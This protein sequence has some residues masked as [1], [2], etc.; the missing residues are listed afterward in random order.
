M[1]SMGET[2]EGA[3]VIV[4]GYGVVGSHVARILRSRHPD[5]RLVLTGRNPQAGRR[6][7]QT[8]NAST[9]YMDVEEERPLERLMGRPAAVLAA[10]S[11]PRDRLLVH[12]MRLGVPIADIN[13]AGHAHILDAALRVARER[14][15]TPVLL[16]GGWMSGFAALVC[17]AS[18][19]ALGRVERIDIT[20][21]VSSEDR[22]GP[23]ASGFAR[24]LAWP[25][26][27][28]RA[29]HRRTVHPLT[30]VRRAPCPDGR[31][32]AAALVAT[33]EQ[34]TIPLTLGVETVE[35]RIALWSPTSLWGLVALKRSGALRAMDRPALHWLRDALLHRSGAGDIAGFTT[36]VRSGQRAARI[37]VLDVQGQAHLSA[38][39][40]V[41]AA[42]RILGLTDVAL[43]PGLSF[44]EQS[45]QGARDLSMLRA[46]GVLV[47]EHRPACGRAANVP[48]CAPRQSHTLAAWTVRNGH[49][50][51]APR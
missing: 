45:A 9:S 28:M 18:A 37:D 20:A 31:T 39:G 22:I 8:V 46:A 13:R 16:A 32:R 51:L 4:G 3:L 17:A 30:G 25:Y 41:A 11:D 35:T 19:S 33:L 24:R 36:T 27:G 34:I 23:D 2:S 29:G 21:L 14:P 26:H 43:P 50:E 48:I 47:R 44:P 12:A 42:E 15:S 7:A 38:L 1:R 6:L 49:S 40:G 5:L 10:V